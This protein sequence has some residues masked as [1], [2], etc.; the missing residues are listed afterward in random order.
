M[1]QQI[2]VI[3]EFPDQGSTINAPRAQCYLPPSTQARHGAWLALARLLF[4]R[5]WHTDPLDLRNVE[6]A[7]D[8][9]GTPG[10]LAHQ[11]ESMVSVPWML[12][13][14]INQKR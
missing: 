6:H 8:A 4:D 1:S 12:L 7:F 3:W 11:A 10:A 9:N 5:S 13:T 14:S 2:I